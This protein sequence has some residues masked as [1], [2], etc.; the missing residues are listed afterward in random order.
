MKMDIYYST[1]HLQFSQLWK[2]V[3]HKS[4]LLKNAADIML[5]VMLDNEVLSKGE[6]IFCNIN[7]KQCHVIETQSIEMLSREA[8]R[9]MRLGRTL[10]FSSKF[11]SWNYVGL[12]LSL[13][14]SPTAH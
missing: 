11:N 4:S 8:L 5:D 10:C 12:W 13:H 2:Q 3:R 7:V 9:Q 1:N 6:E 14:M